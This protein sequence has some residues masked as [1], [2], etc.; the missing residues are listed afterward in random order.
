[1]AT[2]QTA[3]KCLIGEAR[4][5]F[6]HV[7]TPDSKLDPNRPRYG[8]VLTFPKTDKELY[9]KIENA[10]EE[11]KDKTRT[12][13]FGGTL[14]RKFQ[15]VEIQD[16]EDWDPKFHLEDFWV[17]KASSTFKPEVVKKAKVMGK[18]QLVPITDEDE[19]Y[20]GCYG[21]AS[22]TF[23]GYDK[24]VNKGITCMLNSVLKSKD[25]ERFGEGG[26]N[27]DADYADVIDDIEDPFEDDDDNDVF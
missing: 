27:V 8:V 5:N 16:G 19:F 11:C 15:V 1:M 22:V 23:V 7:F 26:G 10:I 6:V 20:S 12:T 13:M 18:T 17:I 4:M 14:P 21:Y 9:K 24:D 3:V 25:G 2:N